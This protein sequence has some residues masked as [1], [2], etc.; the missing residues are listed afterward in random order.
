MNWLL[1][2]VIG[3]LVVCALEGHFRGFIKIVFSLLAMI[4]TLA[5]VSVAAPKI[6]T[7]I[8]ENTELDERITE[9]CL[10]HVEKNAQD[11]LNREAQEKSEETRQQLEEN[12]ISG[13]ELDALMDKA[14]EA[15]SDAV[16]QA[17]ADSGVYQ[18]MAQKS[19]IYHQLIACIVTYVV[20]YLVL[21][22]IL[23]VLD[24]VVRLPVLKGINR[25]LGM[26]AGSIKGFLIVW[27]VFY[28]IHI[29]A[30]TDLGTRLV[31]YIGENEF[32]AFLYQ[33]NLLVQ[34]FAGVF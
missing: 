6:T 24:L 18:A 11:R 14:A 13:G 8:E 26:L 30:A 25:F 33:H 17:L 32:L 15:G 16:H 34:I 7:Y 23:N 10:E 21:H 9:K 22:I 31:T 2:C 3:I 19:R 5:V 12:G 28:L 20:V 4:I 27:V 1:I 29:M